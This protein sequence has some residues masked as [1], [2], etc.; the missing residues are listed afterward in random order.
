MSPATT[1]RNRFF[2]RVAKLNLMCGGWLGRQVLTIGSRTVGQI[3][4]EIYTCSNVETSYI[5]SHWVKDVPCWF[6]DQKVK[7]MGYWRLKRVSGPLLTP[8]YIPPIYESS[9]SRSLPVGIDD[10]RCFSGPYMTMYSTYDCE[11]SY[12]CTPWVNDVPHFWGG[13]EG[14]GR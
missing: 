4:L 12:M 3:T 10:I 5:C 7:V 13:S 11:T 6:W 1:K 8:V 9:W 2:S 14:Q